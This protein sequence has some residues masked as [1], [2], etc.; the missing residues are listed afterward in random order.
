MNNQIDFVLFVVRKGRFT[1]ELVEYFEIIQES[2]LQNTC[3]NNSAVIVTGCIKG[4]MEKPDQLE[5]EFL[6]RALNSTN[7]VGYEFN[8][9]FDDE[10]ET[11]TNVIVRNLVRRQSSINDLISFLDNQQANVKCDLSFVQNAK[12]TQD[13]DKLK[14]K[15]HI[16][17]RILGALKFLKFF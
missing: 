6:Q 16:A 3:K 9:K 5:N 4:W 2:L 8:L 10:D 15:K 12:V 14:K 7:R 1:N 11:D 17:I 13:M